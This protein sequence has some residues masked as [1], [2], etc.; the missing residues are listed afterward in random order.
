MKY[1]MIGAGRLGKN[2]AYALTT[3]QDTKLGSVC[4]L[5]FQNSLRA[6]KEIGSG[7]A[8]RSLK[9]LPKSDVTWITCNDDAIDPVVTQLSQNFILKPGSI[10]VHCSGALNSTLLA[11]LRDQGCSVASFH[12]LKAFRT[13]YLD[14]QAF[15]QVDCV[16][17]GDPDA[18]AWLKNIFR[19]LGA[20]LISIKPEAKIIY[21]AAAT[22]ASNYLI[23][24][25]SSSEELLLQAGMTQH[26]ART[27]ICNLMQGNIN[28][29]RQTEQIAD[30]LTGPL[31]RGDMNTLSLHLQAI[32]KSA[33]KE[34]YK[35]AGL[36]TLPLTQLS[37]KQQQLIKDLF[38]S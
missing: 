37:E 10:V 17:E 24:L 4:N 25:A 8:V 19:D 5:N 27:M 12:P 14:V 11:P 22:I 9:E 34:L 1:N 21:H 18:C 6:C 16:L 30:S 3:T 31:S 29:L 15:N 38:E 36:T 28:N 26:Q 33:T 35:K 7:T 20:N 2:I 23:T 32:D 13:G